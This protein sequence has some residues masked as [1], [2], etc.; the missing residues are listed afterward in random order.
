M[1]TS[2]VVLKAMLSFLSVFN[3][4]GLVLSPEREQPVVTQDGHAFYQ[5]EDGYRDVTAKTSV[6]VDLA[7]PFLLTRAGVTYVFG[8]DA[9]GLCVWDSALGRANC[10]LRGDMTGV[11]GVVH[12]DTFLFAGTVRGSADG[13]F[14]QEESGDGTLD[15]F[16]IAMKDLGMPLRAKRYAGGINEVLTVLTD[17]ETLLAAGWKGPG[18]SGKGLS[19]RGSAAENAYVAR[20]DPLDFAIVAFAVIPSLGLPRAIIETPAGLVIASPAGL[21]VTTDELSVRGRIEEDLLGAGFFAGALW[22]FTPDEARALDLETMTC[23]GFVTYAPAR[24]LMF[25]ADAFIFH[26]ESGAFQGEIYDLSQFYLPEPYLPLSENLTVTGL[27][28]PCACQGTLA[29]GDFTPLI[30]GIYE[31]VFVYETVSGDV[32]QVKRTQTVAAYE[33]V[34]DGGIYP[35]GYR[36]RF[37]GTGTLDGVLVVNGALIEHDGAHELLLTAHDGTTRC[38]RFVT[39]AT[40]VSFSETFGYRSVVTD[41]AT[42]AYHLSCAVDSVTVNGVALA[43]V[44][45]EGGCVVRLSLPASGV[46]SFAL[47]AATEDVVFY[48][49]LSVLRLSATPRLSLTND[50]TRLSLEVTDPEGCARKLR[51]VVNQGEDESHDYPLASGTLTLEALDRKK[52]LSL[53]VYLVTDRGDQV[54]EE[55]LIGRYEGRPSRRGRAVEVT[56]LSASSRVTAITIAPGTL[57]TREARL[58]LY[59][60]DALVH[61]RAGTSVLAVLLIAFLSAGT[62]VGSAIAFSHYRRKRKKE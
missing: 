10:I 13:F 35:H 6:H 31:R 45:E 4:F 51:L 34:H 41:D 20:I 5:E 21:V 17:G 60:S 7:E 56:V 48:E 40:Q 62:G 29:A 55:T 43:A 49:T 14:Y 57:F 52:N 30:N 23:T 39:A 58:A 9:R 61:V 3:P 53:S 18:G 12:E 47:M 38:F 1:M 36:L 46:H 44:R 24:T 26:G 50:G 11:C 59:A 33:N 16:F 19:T 15:V 27:H 2:L 8:R 32:F 42:L 28:G 37:T 54:E 22:I 25:R